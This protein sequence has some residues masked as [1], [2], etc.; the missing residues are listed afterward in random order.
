VEFATGEVIREYVSKECE[1]ENSDLARQH[2]DPIV[3]QLVFIK[4]NLVKEKDGV[5]ALL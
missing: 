5:W 2:G 1:Y 3:R 4:N